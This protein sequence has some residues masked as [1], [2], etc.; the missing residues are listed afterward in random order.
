MWSSSKSTVTI[1]GVRYEGNS[2]TV[3]GNKIVIDGKSV[4]MPDEKDILIIVDGNAGNI[5]VDVCK[6]IRI[7]GNV[8]GDIKTQT[9]DVTVGDVNGD[10]TT[11]TGDVRANN[12]T[13]KVKTQTGDI[14]AVKFN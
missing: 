11:Q 4:S 12:I 10:I 8:E 3:S 1:N 9:G 13:G 14:K 2:V 6:E 7:G 5:S